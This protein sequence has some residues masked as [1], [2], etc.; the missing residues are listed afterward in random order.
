MYKETH[1]DVTIRIK[2]LVKKTKPNRK[3][4]QAKS[5]KTG[6]K[7]LTF[8]HAPQA[9]LVPCRWKKYSKLHGSLYLYI[10]IYI[11]ILEGFLSEISDEP[12]QIFFFPSTEDKLETSLNFC[13]SSVAYI[14]THVY[15][16]N[17]DMYYMS[18]CVQ[19]FVYVICMYVRVHIQMNRCIYVYHMCIC[20]QMHVY[21]HNEYIRQAQDKC[22]V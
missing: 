18:I 1:T 5:N 11:Y 4:K 7:K 13:F 8:P 12:I 19:L 20:I 14:I 9:P 10:Y 2:R 3:I 16:R 21:V 17:Y 22:D 6:K 15:Q